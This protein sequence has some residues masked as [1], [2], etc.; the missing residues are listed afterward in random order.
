MFCCSVC[1]RNL[2][3]HQGP[4]NDFLNVILRVL[5]SLRLPLYIRRSEPTH[6]RSHLASVCGRSAVAVQATQSGST[7]HAHKARW[8]VIGYKQPFY[9]SNGTLIIA[10]A[11]FVLLI[12]SSFP[13]AIARAIALARDMPAPIGSVSFAP[14][15]AKP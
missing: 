10:N 7:D 4:V 5:S 11:P 12:S 2:S 14:L 6:N 3:E 1:G 8:T 15:S 13:L 9:S